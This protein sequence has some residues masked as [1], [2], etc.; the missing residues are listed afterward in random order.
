[1]WIA[2]KAEVSTIDYLTMPVLNHEC[3]RA[4]VFG[5][6]HNIMLFAKSVDFVHADTRHRRQC[7]ASK[8]EMSI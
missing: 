6:E 7:A 1:M 3:Q 5:Q 2:G 4:C 8:Q